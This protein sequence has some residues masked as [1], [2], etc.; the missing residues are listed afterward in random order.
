[1][2]ISRL[3]GLLQRTIGLDAASIGTSAIER[4]V[5]TR[6]G[7]CNLATANLYW[8]LASS[9]EAELQRLVE[10]VVIPETWFFRDRE[11][12]A[13][14]T[15]YALEEWSQERTE[16]PRR[17]LSVPCSTGEEP[18]SMAMALLDA[19][20]TAESFRIDA[21]DVST[22]AIACAHEARFG[23]NSF[24]G[25]DLGFRERH[26]ERVGTDYRV[27]DAVRRQ[28]E[29]RQGNLFS[30]EGLPGVATYH[31]VFCRNLLIYFDRAGQDHAV[32]ALRQL[33]AP[34]ALLFVGPS[35]SALLLS[36]DFVSMKMP[37]AFAFRE[38]LQTEPTSPTIVAVVGAPRG[39]RAHPRRGVPPR[40]RA[41]SAAAPD[42]GLDSA[43]ALANQGRLAEAAKL[44]AAHLR[45]HTDSVPALHLMG[46][47]CSAQGDLATAAQHYRKALYLDPNHLDTLLH[48]GLLLEKQGDAPAARLLR[49][50]L[51]RATPQGEAS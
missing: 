15:Q 39:T 29:F 19:G 38:R 17:L 44:C 13:A 49:E 23:R 34:G 35:E 50:R 30:G 4:A 43:S 48:L 20:L 10:E 47:I 42:A 5:Q 14:L 31:A 9:S 46:L 41:A 27:A 45:T 11:A 24:R 51:Q 3:A 8:D 22:R 21:V 12:F 18:Y 7:V 16:E 37:L 6:R 26:F 36:H 32:R 25:A 1:M 28:V 33:L 2:S 40:E